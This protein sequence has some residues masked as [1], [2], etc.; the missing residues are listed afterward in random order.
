[1]FFNFEEAKE[2]IS[3]FS[4]GTGKVLSVFYYFNIKLM[5]NDSI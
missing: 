5:Q 3:N 2:T 1:M 4:Q